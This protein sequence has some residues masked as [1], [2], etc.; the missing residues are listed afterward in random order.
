MKGRDRG[1]Q[2]M[3]KDEDE[4]YHSM[5]EMKEINWRRN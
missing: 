1:Q 4:E 5:V 2:K 3:R